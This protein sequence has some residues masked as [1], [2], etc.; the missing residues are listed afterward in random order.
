MD[1]NKYFYPVSI[2]IIDEVESK[3]KWF[4]E[5]NEK[6]IDYL[7]ESAPLLPTEGDTHTGRVNDMV[8]SLWTFKLNKNLPPSIHNEVVKRLRPFLPKFP[9]KH[10]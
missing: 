7:F 4:K 8:V 9:R 5:T 6:L 3:I 1:A 10:S 2:K